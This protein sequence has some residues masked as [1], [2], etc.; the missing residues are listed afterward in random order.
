MNLPHK[1]L[2]V[3]LLLALGLF[4]SAC[5]SDGIGESA[6]GISGRPFFDLFEGKDGEYYFHL[7]AANHEVVLSSEGYQNRSGALAGILSVLDNSGETGSYDLCEASN[8]QFYFVLKAANGQ[9]IGRSEL[10]S[11]KS[12]ATQGIHNVIEV[13]GDYLAFVATRTGARF[14]V[15]EGQNGLYYFN[16]KAANGEIVLSSQA[17]STEA[18]AM[19]GTFAVAEVGTSSS[20]Y[21]IKSSKDGGAYFSLKAANGEI[22]GNSEIYYSSS[23][24]RRGRNQVIALLPNV[25]IL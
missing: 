17:Y 19:N 1:S 11:T 18:D 16:L 21:V 5:M 6:N 15:F 22:I 14:T 7:S 12:N 20:N 2:L 23:N 3:T 25:D 10:Y 24:A 9:V 13:S 4:S 8:G